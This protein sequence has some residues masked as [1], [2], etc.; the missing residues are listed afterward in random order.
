MA[1]RK[2]ILRRLGRRKRYR[3]RTDEL[4]ERTR[5]EARAMSRRRRMEARRAVRPE[6][7][8]G[9]RLRGAAYET[10]RRLRPVGAPIAALFAWV[11][12]PI[13]RVLLFVIQLIAALIALILEI[14]QI[15]IRWV[16]GAIY[17]AALLIVEA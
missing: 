14:G 16:A 1:P 7:D 10:R 9:V 6:V 4:T 8:L 13:V 15:V 17:G 12:R 2:G 5:Q 3:S 11:G